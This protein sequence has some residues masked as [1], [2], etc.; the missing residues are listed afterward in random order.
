MN[1][2]GQS[3]LEYLVTYGWAILA[4]VI[5]AAVL[6]ALGIFDPNRFSG[7]K[8]CGGYASLACI[9]YTADVTAGTAT[10]VFGNAAGGPIQFTGTTTGSVVCNPTSVGVNV[11]SVC[12]YTGLALTAGADAAI[13]IEYTLVSSN[14]T[15]SETGFIRIPG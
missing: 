12:D 13:N 4:I 11:Q 15:H 2:K 10:V 5:I 9:D 14:L 7:S 3:A 6:F 8:Q 1:R